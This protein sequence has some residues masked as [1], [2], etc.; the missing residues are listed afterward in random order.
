MF[1]TWK[2]VLETRLLSKYRTIVLVLLFSITLR[3]T[4]EKISLL[5]ILQVFDIRNIS[6]SSIKGSILVSKVNLGSLDTIICDVKMKTYCVHIMLVPL[7]V[8][9][10]LTLGIVHFVYQRFEFRYVCGHF[11]VYS[12]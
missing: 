3:P 4:G 1:I 7:D 9:F 10:V 5:N 11:Y 8:L 12:I 2:L 6:S